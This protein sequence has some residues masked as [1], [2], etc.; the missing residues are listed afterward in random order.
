[1]KI[2]TTKG[3]EMLDEICHAKYGNDHHINKVLSENEGLE[4]E[5]FILPRGLSIKLPEIKTK[6]ERGV[7]LW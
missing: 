7:S 2:Y 1:M 6:R 3:G 5:P 4:F